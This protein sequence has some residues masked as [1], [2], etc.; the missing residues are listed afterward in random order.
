MR[1]EDV[2][3]GVHVD[4]GAE[5][6]MRSR[7]VVALEEVLGHDLPVGIRAEL[8]PRVEG[9]GVEVEIATQDRRQVAEPVGERFRARI[10]VHEDKRA[11]DSD[12]RRQ[13]RELV[14]LEPVRLAIRSR[15]R[16]ERAVEAVR[17]GVVVALDRL[18]AP[19]T[20]GEDRASVAADVEEGA[21][22]AVRTAGDQQRDAAGVCRQEGAGLGDLVGAPAV[23][24]GA[25][26]DALAFAAQ[27]LLVAVPGEGKRACGGRRRHPSLAQ[28]SPSQ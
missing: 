21:Q 27:H 24:P 25:G 3:V 26:E 13:E 22:L 14:L 2:P 1:F 8:D 10:R 6:W 15:C 5:P 18:A 16:P 20:L 4:G 23:L 12:A 19:A 9:D 11:P 28:S 7:A 17:P